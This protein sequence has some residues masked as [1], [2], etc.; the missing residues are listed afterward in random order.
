MAKHQ[1]DA[2][3]EHTHTHSPR[4]ECSSGAPRIFITAPKHGR[5]HFTTV[6]SPHPLLALPARQIMLNTDLHNPNIRTENRMSCS[7]FVRNNENYGG[8]ISGGR[9]L[10]VDYLESVYTSIKEQPIATSGGG[11]DDAVTAHG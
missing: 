4:R 1:R 11:P 2:K 3:H 7:A 6:F 9:D 10:P 8:D 5:L